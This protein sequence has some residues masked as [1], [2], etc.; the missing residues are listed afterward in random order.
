MQGLV[1]YQENF[2]SHSRCD[3]KPLRGVKYERDTK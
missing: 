1:G 3:R 2:G